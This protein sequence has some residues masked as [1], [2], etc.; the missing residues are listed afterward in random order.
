MCRSSASLIATASPRGFAIV[1]SIPTPRPAADPTPSAGSAPTRP[2]A[3]LSP[4]SEQQPDAAAVAAAR[5]PQPGGTVGG[6]DQ[7]PPPPRPA[8]SLLPGRV[9]RA[10]SAP[11]FRLVRSVQLYYSYIVLFE[12]ALQPVLYISTCTRVGLLRYRVPGTY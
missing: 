10:L 9:G 5:S 2:A 7:P 1:S 8:C 12:C 11:L 6:D 4:S 3:A